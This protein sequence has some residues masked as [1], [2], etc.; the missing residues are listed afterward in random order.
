MARN[1][2]LNF[3]CESINQNVA[4]FLWHS[5][6]Y[7]N[8]VIVKTLSFY[9]VIVFSQWNCLLYFLVYNMFIVKLDKMFYGLNDVNSTKEIWNVVV[10]VVRL[11]CMQDFTKQKNI[12]FNG[13]NATRPISNFFI[14]VSI[15]T[16]IILYVLHLN[17]LWFCIF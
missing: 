17:I 9:S 7:I 5:T 2:N 12:V 11:W 4:S 13:D 16:Y 6:I 3:S 14:K 8:F 1:A 15:L 10:R